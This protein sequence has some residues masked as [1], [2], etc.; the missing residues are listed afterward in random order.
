LGAPSSFAWY[1]H[2]TGEHA[3]GLTDDGAFLAALHHANLAQGLAIEALR[4]ERPRA[5]LGTALD[6]RPFVPAD[7]SM[8]A[9]D[10]AAL[11]DAYW[12]GCRLEPLLDGRYPE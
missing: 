7:D 11:M 6:L 8:A 5:R 12:N 4:D 1:G 10:A 9:A 3:P 2:A